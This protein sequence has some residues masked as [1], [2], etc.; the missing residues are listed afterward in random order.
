MPLPNLRCHPLV[1]LTALCFLSTAALAQTPI[2][3]NVTGTLAAGIYVTTN[4]LVVPAGQTLTLAAGVIIKFTSSGHDFSVSGTLLANG[5]AG[6][7]VILTAYADDSAGGDTN[8]NGPSSGVATAWRGLLIGASSTGTTLNYLD[9]RYGGSGFVAN[10]WLDSCSPTLNHCVSRDNYVSGMTLNGTATPIVANCSFVNNGGVAIDGVQMAALPGFSNNTATGNQGNAGNYAR[11]VYGAVNA[12]LTVGPAAM[13]S[14]AIVIDGAVTVAATATWTLLP[15]TV[16]KWRNSGCELNVLGNLVVNGT[17]ANNVVFTGLTDDSIGGDTNGNGASAGAP[18]SWR[19]IGFAAGSAGTLS[20]ADIR[21]G[22]AGFVPNVSVGAASPTL[23]HCV[24]RENFTHGMTCNG[25]GTP[26]VTNCTFL[27]NNGFAVSDVPI[28]SLPGFSNNTATGNAYNYAYV[29]TVTLNSNLTLGPASMLNGAFV[30][31]SVTVAAGRTLTLQPGVV[32]KWRTSGSEALISGNLVCN[33]TPTNKVVFTGITDDSVGGDTNSNGASSGNTASWRGISYATGGGGTMD[34]T[35]VR[36]GGAGFVANLSVGDAAPVLRNCVIRDNFTHGMYLAPLARPIVM[37]CLFSNN[38]GSAVENVHMAAIP[39][40]T[41]NTATGNARNSLHVTNGDVTGPL[42]IGPQS[43]L[44]GAFLMGANLVVTNTGNLT[45]QQGVNFKFESGYNA[46]IDGAMQLRGTS[47]EPVVFTT[48]ADDAFGG[49]TNG[50]GPSTGSPAGWQGMTIQAAAAACSLENVLLRYT[51]SGFV[52]ALTCSS[53]LAQ[54]RSVRAHQGY[55]RGLVL[56]ACASAVNLV[57]WGC[58][59]HGFHL[60][61]GSFNL[62]HATS[63]GN[64]TGMRRETAWTGSV[65]NSI[66][67][68]NG[69]N[70]ANF[71]SAQVLWSCGGFAGSNGNLNVDP[72][73]VGAAQ[74]DLHL[75]ATSPVLGQ[76]DLLQAFFVVKDH[77]ENSRILDHALIGLPLPDMGAFERSAWE[78][79]ATGTARLGGVL[80]W[81]VTGQPGFSFYLVG[82]L[83]DGVLPVVPYGI[84]LCGSQVGNTVLGLPGS[85]LLVGQTYSLP[86]P[87]DPGT[88]GITVGIQTLTVPVASTSV[89]NLTRMQRVLVRP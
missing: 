76:A 15:G 68:G 49:D 84:L 44:T 39:G 64:G 26:T 56:D 66:S 72:Q 71:T 55:D 87:N 81:T 77:D 3:G 37:N 63:N 79:A 18:T 13:I 75:Q 57:A 59:N 2:G 50:N 6:S 86:V 33:G 47:Y 23:D 9:V 34:W 51:G 74:G 41:N 27:N 89:G 28:T 30:L 58:G 14:G 5:T 11:V 43:L 67:Y 35:E 10:I 65:M 69:T 42:V 22:G 19:G 46:I 36:Y 21:Y 20:Y 38:N 24:L 82:F 31:D 32:V 1:S 40:F 80:S 54:L 53:P 17:A 4:S 29:P 62:V 73:F 7:P 48:A 25:V 52:A 12:N 88:I 8:A 78:M 16:V 61:G 85:P 70:F 45:V 83:S 60:T